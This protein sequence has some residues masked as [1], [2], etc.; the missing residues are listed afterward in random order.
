M[1]PEENLGGALKA[2]RKAKHLS[3]RQVAG[4]QVSIAQL[5][6]FERGLSTLSVFSFYHCL[7]NMDLNFADFQYL[8][9]QIEAGVE[10]ELD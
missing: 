6:R 9:T 8:L 10:L 1:I 5:S 4:D 3:L 2:I 7:I